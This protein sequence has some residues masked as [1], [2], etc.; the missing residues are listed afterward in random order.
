MILPDADAVAA[1]IRVAFAAQPVATDP[2]MSA[3]LVTAADVATHLERGGG[4]AVAEVG[5][6][7]TG[8]ALWE[9]QDG[10]LQV[11][12]VAVAPGWRRRGIGRALMAAAEAA[13]REKRLPRLRLATRLV[14]ADN[15]R[16]FATCG[17]VETQRTAHPGYA[18]ATSVTMEKD[19]TRAR[20]G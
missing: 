11:S 5:G 13:A 10:G 17:F 3:L 19:L 15:R 6:V 12:R 4:G 8:S 2:P 16:L 7:L 9:E 18:N 1:L 20:R 14:L